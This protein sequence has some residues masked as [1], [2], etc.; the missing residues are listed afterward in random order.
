MSVFTAIWKTRAAPG[1]EA[2]SGVLAI[3]ERVATDAGIDWAFCDTDS[4]ALAQPEGVDD[5]RFLTGCHAVVA[6]FRVLNPYAKKGDL[7]KIEDQNYRVV[8]GAISN[9]LD[10]LYCYAISAKRYALFNRAEN[11]T[12]ILHKVSAHGL[13]HLVAPYQESEA[14]TSIPP[15]VVSLHSL[16]VQR[17]QYDVWCRIVE[18]VLGSTPDQIRLHDLVGFRKPAT[19]RYAATTPAVLR[20]FDGFNKGK[21]YRERVRPFGFLSAFQAKSP[22]GGNAVRPVAPYDRDGLVAADHCFD[23]TWKE[24]VDRRLLLT[25]AEALAPYH[26]Y[27]EAKFLHA[28]AHDTGSTRRRHIQVDGVE[29]IGKEANRWEEQHLLGVDPEAQIEYGMAPEILQQLHQDVLRRCRASGIRKVATRAGLSVRELHSLLQGRNRARPE[30]MQRLRAACPALE[31]EDEQMR[32]WIEAVLERTRERVQVVSVRELAREAGI[33][34]SNLAHVLAEKRKLP[35][36]V[37]TKLERVLER[38]C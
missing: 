13:G 28:D 1:S 11:H 26:L 10:P 3:T 30:T 36:R 37:A 2:G 27:P 32:E 31:T 18:T 15:P 4:M 35:Q 8:D 9:E 22:R 29:H 19:S 16:G 34:P 20:W 21:P 23:R 6:W 17:W 14:P 25:Y 33:D 24:P 5:A 7:L 38:G 12:P